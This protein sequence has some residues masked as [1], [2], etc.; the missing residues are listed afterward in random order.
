MITG[1]PTQ[2][3]NTEADKIYA[4]RFLPEMF[5]NVQHVWLRQLDIDVATLPLEDSIF[6]ECGN[7]PSDWTDE[8]GV[9]G[10]DIWPQTR[11]AAGSAKGGDK[12]VFVRVGKWNGLPDYQALQGQG[13]E[14]KLYLK[15]L[16]GR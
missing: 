2:E 11:Q 6:V 12:L 14:E 7:R 15:K 13:D 16:R 5:E 9:G 8:M 1:Y 10:W 4:E 3:M